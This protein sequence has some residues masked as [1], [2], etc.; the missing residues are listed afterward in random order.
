MLPTLRENFWSTQPSLLQS[1]VWRQVRCLKI[2]DDPKNELDHKTENNLKNYE[3]Y[4][5]KPT[6]K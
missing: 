1:R 2:E 6:P 5:M 4:K 3:N